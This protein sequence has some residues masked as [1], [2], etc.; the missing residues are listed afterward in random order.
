MNELGWSVDV[1]THSIVQVIKR[2]LSEDWDD[3][4]GPEKGEPPEEP[5]PGRNGTGLTGRRLVGQGATQVGKKR[6]KGR[7]V[8]KPEPERDCVDC[9]KCESRK[10]FLSSSPSFMGFFLLKPLRCIIRGLCGRPVT[11]D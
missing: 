4:D 9:Y 3:G 11:S 2:I 6:P 1:R 7:A 5:E 10:P 8:P